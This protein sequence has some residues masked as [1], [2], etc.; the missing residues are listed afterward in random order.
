VVE[1][2]NLNLHLLNNTCYVNSFSNWSGGLSVKWPKKLQKNLRVAYVTTEIQIQHLR[3]TSQK[4]YHNSWLPLCCVATSAEYFPED[5]G[6]RFLR[7]I[8]KPR[9]WMWIS[10]RLHGDSNLNSHCPDKFK[11]TG[12]PDERHKNKTIISQKAFILH[13]YG[14]HHYKGKLSKFFWVYNFLNK[15]QCGLPWWY[16]KYPDD[17]QPRSTLLEACFLTW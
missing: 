7:N 14:L 17:I 8:R 12:R 1:T 6:S 2:Q 10:T 16:D 15:F 5:R 4:C 3:N 9:R 13:I 11:P